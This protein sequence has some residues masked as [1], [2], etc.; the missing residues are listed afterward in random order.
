M[1]IVFWG[2]KS[3]YFLPFDAER[4]KA[5]EENNERDEELRWKMSSSLLRSERLFGLQRAE[6]LGL[7]GAPLSETENEVNYE[8]GSTGFG[9]EYGILIISFDQENHVTKAVRITH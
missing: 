8:L 3:N 7:L 5:W 2:V 4:W 1:A 9:M 6:V